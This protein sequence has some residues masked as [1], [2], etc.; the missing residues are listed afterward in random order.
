MSNSTSFYT[1]L[2]K[3]YTNRDPY[4]V[5]GA[6]KDASLSDITKKYR[7]EALSVHPDRCKD[8]N[9]LQKRTEPFQLLSSAYET[10]VKFFEDDF[11]QRGGRRED[12][13]TSSKTNT[14][15]QSGS[16]SDPTVN[17][18]DLRNGIPWRSTPRERIQR[19]KDEM[20]FLRNLANTVKRKG[21]LGRKALNDKQLRQAL[22]ARAKDLQ[23][24]ERAIA[25]ARA[26]IEQLTGKNK[27]AKKETKTPG[28][29]ETTETDTHTTDA[30]P[31][32]K[33]CQSL[34]PHRQNT[35]QALQLQPTNS[36]I[37]SEKPSAAQELANQR[38]RAAE[39][40]LKETEAEYRR[41]LKNADVACG[42]RAARFAPK[43]QDPL[44]LSG[45]GSMNPD[46][47]DEDDSPATWTVANRH[48]NAVAES[49]QAKR[50]KKDLVQLAARDLAITRRQFKDAKREAF[51]V[52]QNEKAPLVDALVASRP[53]QV[54]SSLGN[55]AM[56][57]VVRQV[58]SG[59]ASCVCVSEVEKKV[60]SMGM[61][62]GIWVE[63]GQL[64]V[65]REMEGLERMEG[66]RKRDQKNEMGGD[67]FVGV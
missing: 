24:A 35:S 31:I 7:K 36:V 9:F 8:A 12:T 45:G 66:M 54:L 65:D 13:N 4:V 53:G 52:A 61:W 47:P 1:D 2:L 3:R 62:C 37:D 51:L 10:I 34:Q 21:Q 38:L 27:K 63:E 39:Q 57:D 33:A 28:S 14:N 48:F 59:R 23:T 55:G 58:T 22:G 19:H 26:R 25:E 56:M 44:R 30:A 11:V 50:E 41:T 64:E 43:Q 67:D 16:H 20:Q 49:R 6:D 60:R 29:D 46:L 17:L 18:E 5:L 15:K 32:G 40:N 42:S